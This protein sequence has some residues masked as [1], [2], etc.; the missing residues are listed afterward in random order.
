MDLR[1]RDWLALLVSLAIIFALPMLPDRKKTAEKES[2]PF[3]SSSREEFDLKFVKQLQRINP[4]YVFI[5]NSV[6]HSRI[7]VQ[8]MDEIL[9]PKKSYLL[10]QRG[11]GSAIFYVL[12]KHHL[13]HSGIEPDCVF[14]FFRDTL[15]TEPRTGLPDW[16]WSSA[17][18]WFTSTDTVFDQ[19]VSGMAFD[20]R[21]D[22][23]QR[24]REMYP[25]H[26]RRRQFQQAIQR[27][28]DPW[29][30][31]LPMSDAEIKESVNTL[32]APGNMR[33]LQ[34]AEQAQMV[35]Q[36][37]SP[38]D[39]QNKLENSFL[40]HIIRIA[41]KE[42]LKLCFVRTKR[43][44]ASGSVIRQ[45]PEL[46][47]YINELSGYIESKGFLFADFTDDPEITVDWYSNKDYLKEEY[48]ER[49]TRKFIDKLPEVFGKVQD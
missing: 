17:C 26:Q 30:S 37:V 43:K 45:S 33:N 2:L 21:V 16:L 13:V 48:R 49:Y 19:L 7:D 5:G 31:D 42:N 4:D 41:K 3:H 39:F 1:T 9:A 20:W 24:L 35:Q 32:F 22:V 8:Y 12:F 25:V 40:P 15:L 18:H 29:W 47:E 23:H 38:F 27:T 34:Q 10:F 6:L 28:T 46:Q 36:L 44:P 11:S 14:I